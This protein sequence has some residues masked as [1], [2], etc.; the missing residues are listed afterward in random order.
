MSFSDGYI[1][2]F[3]ISSSFHIA[4]LQVTLRIFRFRFKNCIQNYPQVGLSQPIELGRA[5]VVKIVIKDKIPV[6]VDGQPFYQHSPSEII[7]T[8][9]SEATVL[10]NLR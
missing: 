8:K 10:K 6:Q 5:K 9:H 7:L 1:E 4:Q 3:G 2:V